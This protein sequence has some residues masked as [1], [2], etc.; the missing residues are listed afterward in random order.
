MPK[1]APRPCSVPGC[2]RLT[3]DGRFCEEHQAQQPKRPPDN[4]PSAAARGYDHTWRRLRRMILTTSPLCV[5]C[6]KHGRIVLA[7]DVDHIIPL[8]QGG[9]NH[10]NNLQPLC[11]SC[12]SR[13]TAVESSGW[14]K[15][16][17]G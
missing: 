17:G 10:I 3:T 15:G 4:R 9:T 7:T 12:H 13:K 8:S 6:E 5:E 2:P 1:L 11:H 14:G 16:E